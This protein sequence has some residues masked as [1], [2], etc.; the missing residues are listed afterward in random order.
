MLRHY[1][2]IG[3]L[4]PDHVDQFTGYRYYSSEQLVR[5]NQIVA[6]RSMGFGLKEIESIQ[7]K[8]SSEEELQ[9]L[10]QSNLAIK[11][12][13][14]E[15]LLMQIRRIEEALHDAGKNEYGLSIAVKTFPARKVVCLREKI[16]NFSEEGRL[17]VK[18]NE[19]CSRQ[20]IKFSALCSAITVQHG[21]NH[22][23]NEIDTEVQL[24]VESLMEDSRCLKF[25]EVPESKVASITVQGGYSKLADINVYIARWIEQ[26]GYEIAGNVFC[27][28]HRSPKNE[29]DENHFIT[30]VCFPIQ[31][32][33]VTEGVSTDNPV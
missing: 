32:R 14:M 20:T 10:L 4:V 22:N 8:V 21:R 23:E 2:K 15:T 3:L 18:L 11:K 31:V 25:R 13:E 26:N 9:F 6:L 19:E 29:T 33:D 7:R 16:R 17:W 12:Q 28:Y 30:E 27:I 24:T 5:A 1:D